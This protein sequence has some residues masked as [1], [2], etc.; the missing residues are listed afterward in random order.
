[1]RE[2]NRKQMSQLME[3]LHF[4][5]LVRQHLVLGLHGTKYSKIDQ[6]EFFKGCLRQFLLDPFLDTLSHLCLVIPT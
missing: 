4:Y 6:I 3:D 1:M 5:E 2:Q